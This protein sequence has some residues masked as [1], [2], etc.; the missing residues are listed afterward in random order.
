MTRNAKGFMKKYNKEDRQTDE[1]SY[2]VEGRGREIGQEQDRIDM[3]ALETTA[4]LVQIGKDDVGEILRNMG[5]YK[6]EV[7]DPMHAPT[8][9]WEDDCH[10]PTVK[11]RAWAD[12]RG[13]RLKTFTSR[14]HGS[15]YVVPDIDLGADKDHDERKLQHFSECCELVKT[16]YDDVGDKMRALGVTAWRS[17]YKVVTHVSG[18]YYAVPKEGCS[19]TPA[20]IERAWSALENNR[21]VEID[22][23]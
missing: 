2:S 18:T 8:G 15:Y 7:E 12:A 19:L 20:Q 21:P 11:S 17:A 22:N 4:T 10:I 16:D 5:C 6:I 23:E 3:E 13:T 1:A 9:R 14:W